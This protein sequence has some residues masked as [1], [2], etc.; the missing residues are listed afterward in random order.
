MHWK[1]RANLFFSNP[2]L[3]ILDHEAPQTECMNSKFGE[4]CLRNSS[5]SPRA[6]AENIVRLIRAP[7]TLN[8]NQSVANK[9]QELVYEVRLTENLKPKRWQSETPKHITSSRPHHPIT[10]ENNSRW[11]SARTSLYRRSWDKTVSDTRLSCPK[12]CT[13]WPTGGD[14]E[15][16]MLASVARPLTSSILHGSAITLK[17]VFSFL[18]SG[19]RRA[20]LFK[21]NTACRLQCYR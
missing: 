1:R 12:A 14:H 7:V 6:H 4:Q 18:A 9:P 16:A 17:P 13:Q 21:G 20:P 3:K 2:T 19:K 11:H 15:R 10:L 5:T 8:S